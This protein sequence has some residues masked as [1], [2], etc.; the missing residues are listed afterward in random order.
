MR[1][2]YTCPTHKDLRID[3]AHSM[4]EDPV[5]LCPFCGE[6]L[7]R[8]PQVPAGIMHSPMDTFFE[9]NDENYKRMRARKRGHHAPRFSPD[10][11]NRPYGGLPKFTG[12]DR[13]QTRKKRSIFD[14]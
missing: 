13:R 1:Y 8:V 3:K 11:V 10:H 5:Y 14:E 7:H 9:W 4:T 2:V 12:D 6:Q